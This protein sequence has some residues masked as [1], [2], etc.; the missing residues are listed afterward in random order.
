M[1]VWWEGVWEGRGVIN[2]S[3]YL[4]LAE[5]LP[6][7]V[8]ATCTVFSDGTDSGIFILLVVRSSNPQKIYR[9]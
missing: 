4:G 5:T 9:I 3:G 2:S 8:N 1:I 7:Y 6:V